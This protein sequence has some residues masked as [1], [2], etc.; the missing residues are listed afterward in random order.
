[1]MTV[2]E[3]IG[4]QPCLAEEWETLKKIWEKDKNEGLWALNNAYLYGIIQGKRAERAR[5]K[6]KRKPATKPR[7]VV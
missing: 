3:L 6:G 4:Y 1:M 7:N 2:H 5:R